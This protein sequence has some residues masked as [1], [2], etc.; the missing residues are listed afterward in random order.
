MFFSAVIARLPNAQIHKCVSFYRNE[1]FAPEQPLQ[2][3]FF[4]C[5]CLS[6]SH[7]DAVFICQL[8][9]HKACSIIPRINPFSSLLSKAFYL[10]NAFLKKFI[11]L[12]L[13]IESYVSHVLVCVNHK[14]E[15]WHSFV[16][17]PGCSSN[18][19]MNED[20]THCLL[21]QTCTHLVPLG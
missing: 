7:K 12:H 21:T 2:C 8:N 18:F 20:F 17:L 15:L 11:A 6:L 9:K 13:R 1:R 16:W 5:L 19:F 10:N 4:L 14:E 3:L